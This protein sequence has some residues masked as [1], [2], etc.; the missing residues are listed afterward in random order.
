MG[1]AGRLNVT[2]GAAIQFSAMK[3]QPI[4]SLSTNFLCSSGF[5]GEAD[6]V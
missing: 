1:A 4:E 5:F 2:S 3:T 6:T